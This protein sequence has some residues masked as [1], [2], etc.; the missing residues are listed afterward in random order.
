L[1][2][3]ILK[4]RPGDFCTAIYARLRPSG[5]GGFEVTMA[6]GGHP[7]P[8]VLRASGA[9]ERAGANGTLLGVIPQPEVRDRTLRLA[10]GDALILYTDGLIE[11]RAP[12]RI[13]TASDLASAV[14][15]CAGQPASTILTGIE[16]ALLRP[17]TAQPRD[18][19]AV[20]VVR[21]EQ[22]G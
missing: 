9:V 3:E 16:G 17:R 13:A 5:D 12:G 4:Q 22:R 6:N 11:A 18:D 14:R 21:A 20:I 7:L 10:D 15:P 2:E 8:L 19:I 1:N